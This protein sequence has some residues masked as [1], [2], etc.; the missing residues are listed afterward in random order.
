ML[1]CVVCGL[2]QNPFFLDVTFDF[3]VC[4]CILFHRHWLILKDRWVNS[5]PT[6][7]VSSSLHSFAFCFVLFVWC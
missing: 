2:L 7:K 5:T 4:L 6:V 3:L 1:T